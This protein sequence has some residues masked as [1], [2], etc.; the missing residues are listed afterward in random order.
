MNNYG[1]LTSALNGVH[2]WRNSSEESVNGRRVISVSSLTSSWAWLQWP[3]LAFFH[4]SGCVQQRWVR[5]GDDDGAS[6]LGFLRITTGL[7]FWSPS[8]FSPVCLRNT[9]KKRRAWRVFFRLKMV[10]IREKTWLQM[11]WLHLSQLL[12]IALRYWS[13]D[14]FVH[15][16]P[17][18]FLGLLARLLQT[19]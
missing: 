1:L 11:Y 2:Y 6:Y 7:S 10:Q 13:W 14:P 19:I 5:F 12:D 17:L 18:S 16:D 4:E 15:R 3:S 8:S 9:S